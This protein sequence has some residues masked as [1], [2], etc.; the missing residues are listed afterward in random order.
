MVTAGHD[1]RIFMLGVVPT[2]PSLWSGVYTQ[3]I[4][5][6]PG[7]LVNGTPIVGRDTEFTGPVGDHLCHQLTDFSSKLVDMDPCGYAQNLTNDITRSA[8]QVT[9]PVQDGAP[10]VRPKR[11]HQLANSS[12]QCNGR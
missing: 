11:H 8:L 9:Q 2:P 7:V 10:D 3:P 6:R 5:T 4:E 1:R 12:T